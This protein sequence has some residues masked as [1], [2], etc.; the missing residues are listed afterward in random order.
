MAGGFE[1]MS[2]VPYL[3]TSA[4]FGMRYGNGVVDDG[5]LKDGLWDGANDRHTVRASQC[6][7]G[8]GGAVPDDCVPRCRATARRR[9]HSSTAFRAKTRTLSRRR[10]TAGLKPPSR[11]AS[12]SRA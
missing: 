2:N 6:V 9:R 1:S 8:G 4:R 12:L 11:S 7:G 3:L 5:L 10:R